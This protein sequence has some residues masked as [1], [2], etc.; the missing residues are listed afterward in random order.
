MRDSM[1]DEQEPT[2]GRRVAELA[3]LHPEKPAIIFLPIDGDEL[4]LTWNQLDRQ[5][6]Q[7]ARLLVERGVRLGTTV[8]VGL[9]NSPEHVL[10]TTAAWK[11]R[12]DSLPS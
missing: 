5:S 4:T 9:W 7:Y 3:E 8:V 11:L 10:L 2:F 1:D 12:R 6:N